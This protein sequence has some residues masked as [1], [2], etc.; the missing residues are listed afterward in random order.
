MGEARRQDGRYWRCWGDPKRSQTHKR[1]VRVSSPPCLGLFIG[2]LLTALVSLVYGLGRVCRGAG[3]RGG[4]EEGDPVDG[5]TGWLIIVAR[6]GWAGR[7]CC[8]DVISTVVVLAALSC[9]GTISTRL[10]T[11]Q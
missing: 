11:R 8:C 10:S 5:W 4:L 7:N 3:K 9:P 6:S 1:A 2:G